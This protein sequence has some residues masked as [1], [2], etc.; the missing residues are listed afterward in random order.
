M[1]NSLTDCLVKIM[2]DGKPWTFW[3]LQEEIKRR[4]DVFYGEP[5]ISAGIRELRRHSSRKKYR[6]I[7]NNEEAS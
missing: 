4:Y 2:S 1:S 5:T 6:L 7:T 3:E